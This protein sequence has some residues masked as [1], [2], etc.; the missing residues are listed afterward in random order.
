MSSLPIVQNG[1][2]VNLG[3]V[4]STL[5]R[6]D[7]LRRLLDSLDGE[8]LPGD[9]VVIVA[10]AHRSE[11]EAL[12][13]DY[14]LRGMDI[15]V[16]TSARGAS[17][18]RN[19]GVAALGDGERLLSFP[20][21]TTWYP[22]GVLGALRERSD[23]IEAGALTVRDEHGPKFALPAAGTALDRWNVWSVIE[24]GIVMRTSTFERLGGFDPSI[25]TG[26]AS[27]WQAGEGTDLLLRLRSAEPALASRFAWMP[28]QIWI[29]GIADAHGLPRMARR[30][31]LRAYGRGLGRIV[32]RWRY[33]AWWRFA[34]IGG[35]LAFGLRHRPDYELLDGWWVFLGRLEGAIGRVLG[36]S[37]RTEAVSR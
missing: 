29:G 18:G 17:I 28:P 31:K 23:G 10:Q 7:P 15:V 8:L 6:I 24:M 25:G 36:R 12:V 3:L 37:V 32:T 26:A 27:P 1:S 14:T 11:V 9:R 16:T 34:F 33:P 20:N 21:D 5:G 4:V 22:P 35:G 13:R 30:H 2:I 19:T